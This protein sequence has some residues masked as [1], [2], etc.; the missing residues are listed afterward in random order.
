MAADR[1]KRAED[2]FTKPL[3]T[4]AESGKWELNPPPLGPKP[5]MQPIHLSPKTS[6]VWIPHP[7]LH[8][9]RPDRLS[10]SAETLIPVSSCLTYAAAHCDVL[11]RLLV[12]GEVRHFSSAIF[13]SLTTQVTFLR[14]YGI[15]PLCRPCPLSHRQNYF[16]LLGEILWFK[17]RTQQSI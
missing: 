3:H 1:H 14:L 4:I 5:S 16:N 10:V 7:R 2:R 11:C 15:E 9:H 8:H 6:Q 13:L 12:S 17:P